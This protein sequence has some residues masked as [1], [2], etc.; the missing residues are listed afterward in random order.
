MAHALK[1]FIKKAAET[2]QKTFDIEEGKITKIVEKSNDFVDLAA[3]K[4]DTFEMKT[5]EVEKDLKFRIKNIKEAVMAKRPDSETT[6]EANNEA[7]K[8]HRPP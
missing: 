2:A 1:D 6:S 7:G 8:N 4:L 5:N 3:K